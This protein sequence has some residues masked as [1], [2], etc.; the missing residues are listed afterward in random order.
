VLRE[1]LH[2]IARTPEVGSGKL[3]GVGQLSGVAL[4]IL[5]GPSEAI[6]GQKHLT[7]GPLLM[8]TQ[9]RIAEILGFGEP[10]EWSITWQE[11]TPRD[12]LGEAQAASVKVTSVG[13]SKQTALEELGYDAE[14]EAER[15]AEESALAMEQAQRMI[16]AGVVE[17]PNAPRTPV[18]PARPT[19]ATSARDSSRRPPA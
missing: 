6:L 8:R 4:T 16:G 1:A 18:P 7:Y 17:D 14:M 9:D 13:L 10:G 5:Y 19:D 11:S 2:M 3:E 12:V 15:N